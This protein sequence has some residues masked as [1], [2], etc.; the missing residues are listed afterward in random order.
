MFQSDQLSETVNSI[1]G[2][3]QQINTDQDDGDGMSQD[4]ENKS[5][6][7]ANDNLTI[8]I[9]IPKTPQT[10]GR[11]KSSK[12][13]PETLVQKE[14]R[15]IMAV[16]QAHKQKKEA[17]WNLKKLQMESGIDDEMLSAIQKERREGQIDLQSK[18][19]L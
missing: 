3:G 2:T 5:Q 13:K 4:D 7:G 11:L 1:E 6:K 10:A 9:Q 8:N 12:N 18:V 17:E 16:E 19:T 15:M 14:I